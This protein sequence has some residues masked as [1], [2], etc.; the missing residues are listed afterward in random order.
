MQNLSSQKS[1]SKID[2][3]GRSIL[4]V[5]QLS[6]HPHVALKATWEDERCPE[7]HKRSSEGHRLGVTISISCV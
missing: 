4:F 2:A 6:V 1:F 3:Q 5:L 7:K